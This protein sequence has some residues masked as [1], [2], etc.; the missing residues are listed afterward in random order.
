MQGA[1]HD[2]PMQKLFQIAVGGETFDVT[3]QGDS[4]HYSWTSGPNAGYGFAAGRSDGVPPTEDEASVEIRSF[5]SSIDPTTGY[6]V[7]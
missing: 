5:L 2:G 3:M 6:L 1:C 7:E 4:V